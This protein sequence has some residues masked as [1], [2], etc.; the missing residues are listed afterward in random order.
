MTADL[1]G[2]GDEKAAAFAAMN[3]AMRAGNEAEVARLL[4]KISQW[5]ERD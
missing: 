1:A 2:S 3:D 4:G 5:S